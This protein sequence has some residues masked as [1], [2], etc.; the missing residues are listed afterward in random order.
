MTRR[1][2]TSLT[3]VGEYSSGLYISSLYLTS[4]GVSTDQGCTHVARTY[5]CVGVHSSGLHRC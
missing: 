4:V 1:R 5:R 3:C 2:T